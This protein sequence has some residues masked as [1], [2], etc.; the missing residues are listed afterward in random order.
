VLDLKKPNIT[1]LLAVFLILL[2]ISVGKEII[3]FIVDLQWFSDLNY[4]PVYFRKFLAQ[5]ELAIPIFLITFVFLY[6][7]SV[8]VVNDYVNFAQDIVVKRSAGK[9]K[10][11]GVYTS[12]FVSFLV[13]LYAALSWWNDW[14]FFKNAVSF[15]YSDP[16]FKKDVGFY[17]FRLP[18]VYDIYR[19]LMVVLIL[20]ISATVV[21]YVL[22]YLSDKTRFYEISERDGNLF[23]A[24]YNKEILEKAFR[25]IAPLAA[26]FFLLLAVGYYFARF[27]ILYSTKGRVF[28]ATY[29]DVHVTLTFYY[30]LSALSVVVA[31]LVFVFLMK[32]N[33]KYAII[34][35]LLLPAFSLVMALTETVVQNLIVSPNELDKESRYISY[36]IEYTRKGFG[37]DKVE[38]KDYPSKKE[39]TWEVLQKNRDTIDNIMINDYRPV[40][41][42]Y[43]QLQALRLYYKFNDIDIDRYTING[44]YKQVFIAAR[45]IDQENLSP[46]A[47]TWINLHL[48]YTH[49]YGVVMSLVNDVTPTGQPEM[50]VKDIPPTTSTDIRIDRP[51]IYFGELTNDYVI[52]NT[53][54]GEFDYP[55]GD[56]NIQTNYKGTTGIPM[57]FPNRIL[58]ALYE[59][60]ARILLSA[61]ITKDSKILIHR[62]I[63]ERANKIAPFLLYDDDPYI[64]VSDGKLYW[65]IDAYT[66]ST[67]FP[68]SQPYG[69]VGI[70]YIRN[71]VKV[72]VDAYNGE[73]DFYIADEKDP[74]IQAYKKI[75]PG[76]F[77]DIE[78]MPAGIRQHIRYPQFLFDI[79]TEVYKTYH[80][81]DPQVFYN[82]EDA[83]DIAK[84]KFDNEVQYQESQYMIMRLPGEQKEEFILMIPYTPST[85]ANMVAWMAARMDKDN[86]GKLVVYKFPKNTIVY[87]PLQIENMIDQD[88]NISKELSLW[89]QQGSTVSRGNLLVIPI[90]D[91]ILY[92]EPLYI[93]S[94][95]QNALPEVKRV[96]VAYKDQ[97][98]MEPTLEE[99]LKKVFLGNATAPEIIEKTQEETKGSAEGQRELI[100]KAHDTYEKAVEAVKKGDWA[101]FGK[102]MEELK[103]ILKLLKEGVKD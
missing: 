99:S 13:S 24:I 91:S 46:Q 18:F 76:L 23:R 12:L 97:I 29:T 60:E 61:D 77:K 10:K 38:E 47:K 69:N 73:V 42:A 30:I 103:E 22:M 85:K 94:Q 50:I 62:N 44:K 3:N 81:T 74:L 26:F 4:L 8:K 90:D 28:G 53:K 79:Q 11:I 19:L 32:R 9:Y 71:S 52:V 43:N 45:E 7:Y 51:Q 102:Y 100:I 39:L 57:T 49:G 80:M 58:F 68:Y 1:L 2:V 86:Y 89:N 64:V 66:Y 92:V 37:L 59:K 36:N 20:V 25:E 33:L 55:S 88:P 98:A 101:S 31:F 56:K 67:N 82:K 14:L 95:N 34:S 65:I 96:I 27:Q 72:V 87:G 48:K 83:W 78:K 63:L 54:T 15:N 16:I 35:V 70:N 75:F 17:V 21:A 6:F 84:E 5:L 40:K 41:Q 93:Q